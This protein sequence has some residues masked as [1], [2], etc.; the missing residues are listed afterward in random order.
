LKS[1]KLGIIGCGNMGEAILKGILSSFFLKENQL[2][3]YDKNSYREGY[4]TD[5][6]K[7]VAADDITSLIEKAK[8]ILLAVKPQDLKSV[9]EQIKINFNFKKNSIISI[10]AGIPTSFIEKMLDSD[11]SVVRIMPNTPALYSSGIAAISGGK[12]AKDGDL[13]FAKKLIKSVGDYVLI[14]EKLQNT[15]TALSGSGPAYFFLFCKYL[16]EAGI[17]NGLKPE[18]SRK[19]IVDT[20]IGA[21]VTLK[22][23]GSEPDS[24]IKK[25]ASPGGTTEMALREFEKERIGKIIKKAVDSARKRAYQLQGFLDQDK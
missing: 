22:K 19:L 14:D 6:Y 10:V 3:C 7:V 16:I 9:L 15:V 12:F 13:S 11:A 23:S 8:Y 25:V 21:G 20:M 1:H 2:I 17:E 4:T 24:L 18:I 5:K